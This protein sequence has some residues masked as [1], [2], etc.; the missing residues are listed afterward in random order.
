MP[1]VRL[2]RGVSAVKRTA[3][4]S[5]AFTS[6]G[7]VLLNVEELLQLEQVRA[8]LEGI[9][10][11]TTPLAQWVGTGEALFIGVPLT[12]AELARFRK[13]MDDSLAEAVAH[14]VGQRRRRLVTRRRR[15]TRS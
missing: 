12:P 5:I 8:A 3:R 7:D 10:K 13:R 15:T 2:R 11:G 4:A 1:G 9:P 14:L 6:E